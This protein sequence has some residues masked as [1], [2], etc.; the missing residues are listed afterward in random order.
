MRNQKLIELKQDTRSNTVFDVT[1]SNL[2]LCENDKDKKQAHSPKE[3]GE[4]VLDLYCKC[5]SLDTRVRPLKKKMREYFR[6]QMKKYPSYFIMDLVMDEKEQK[7]KYKVIAA[8]LL[9]DTVYLNLKVHSV[10]HMIAIE[11]GY[12]SKRH[13]DHLFLYVTRVTRLASRPCFAVTKFG[14]YSYKA[15]HGK[16]KDISATF[17][18]PEQVLKDMKFR[19]RNIEYALLDAVSKLIVL[20]SEVVYGKGE[21]ILRHCYNADQANRNAKVL[22]THDFIRH[23]ARFNSD[24]NEYDIYSHT[25]GWGSV[26]IDEASYISVTD[27]KIMLENPNKKLKLRGGGNRQ[28]STNIVLKEEDK[29]FLLNKE[30]VKLQERSS[31]CCVWLAAALAINCFNDEISMKMIEMMR[32]NTPAFEWMFM[33]KIPRNIKEVYRE[34]NRLPLN[35]HLQSRKIGFK[36][37]KIN[38]KAYDYSY[39]DYIFNDETKGVYLCQLETQGGCKKH[40]V[41]I[42]CDRQVIM[43]ACESHAMVLSRTNLDH[44]CG[45]YLLGVRKIYC[46]YKILKN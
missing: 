39:L 4:I 2:I 17:R 43:D 11:P 46:C 28:I 33:T 19:S 6:K 15:L 26:E 20:D 29:K 9:E 41:A 38:I 12:E 3:V 31:N 36:L 30:I 40:V 45:K 10:I 13:I 21:D 14:K 23:M 24:N 44:C 18:N 34:Y 5:Y 35:N 7:K 16:S 37:M 42:D 1:D 8:M 25:F 27:R 32:N 22:L